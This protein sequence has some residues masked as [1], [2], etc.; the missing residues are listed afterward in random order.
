MVYLLGDELPVTGG[1]KTEA[2]WQR[3]AVGYLE[4]EHQENWTAS[5]FAHHFIV[6]V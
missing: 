6:C 3:Q 1:R 2:A 4:Y 5:T